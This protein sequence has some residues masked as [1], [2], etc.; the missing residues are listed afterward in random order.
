MKPMHATTQKISRCPCCQSKYN[1]SQK[2]GGKSSA[3]IKAKRDLKKG[4]TDS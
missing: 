2:K 3:R 1:K 4:L